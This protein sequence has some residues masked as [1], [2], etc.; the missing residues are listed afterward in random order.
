MRT[1]LEDLGLDVTG[2]DDL[3]GEI[4]GDLTCTRTKLVK[5]KEQNNHKPYENDSF[6][7]WEEKRDHTY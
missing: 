6:S 5:E 4:G 7:S 1:L 2:V 3:R